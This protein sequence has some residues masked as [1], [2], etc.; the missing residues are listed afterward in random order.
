MTTPPHGGYGTPP[1]PEGGSGGPTGPGGT[2]PPPPGYGPPPGGG[3]GAPQYPGGPAPQTTAKGFFGALFDF[4]FEHMVTPRIVKFAYILVTVLIALTYL[5][6]VVAAFTENVGAGLL[7]M[8]IIG[9]LLALVY[10]ILARI[11]LEFYRSL[12]VMAADIREMKNARMR[13]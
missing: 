9:P 8:F 5:G 13:L 3:Y 2:P 6:V 7:V 1:E 4:N 11:T 10:L 12:V